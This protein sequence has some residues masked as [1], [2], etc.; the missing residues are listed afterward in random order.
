MAFWKRCGLRGECGPLSCGYSKRYGQRGVARAAVYRIFTQA[1][2]FPRA[3]VL[4]AAHCRP[5]YTEHAMD[6]ILQKLNE[7]G[8]SI[9]LITHDNHLAQMAKRIVTIQ[10]GRILSDRPVQEGVG[11]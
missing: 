9:I 4:P 11:A 1:G 7:Q 8:T 10:D 3:G 2:G 5:F 6:E